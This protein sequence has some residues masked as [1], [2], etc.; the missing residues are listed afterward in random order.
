MSALKLHSEALTQTVT[1]AS[2]GFLFFNTNPIYNKS[3]E[4]QCE[5]ICKYVVIPVLSH[6]IK[7]EH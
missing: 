6:L 4:K 1:Q 3:T 2:M 5:I 7:G